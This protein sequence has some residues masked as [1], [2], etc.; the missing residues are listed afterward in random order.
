[1][2]FTLKPTTSLPNH[3]D[4]LRHIIDVAALADR[5]TALKLAVLSRMTQAW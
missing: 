3:L 5:R 4:L 2:V 1:M